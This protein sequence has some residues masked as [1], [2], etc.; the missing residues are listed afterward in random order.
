ML[1]LLLFAYVAIAFALG[2]WQA[3]V[4]RSNS[5]G[6]GGVFGF[7]LMA[8]LWPLLFFVF[9][10]HGMETTEYLARTRGKRKPLPVVG[11]VGRILKALTTF[12]S[13]RKAHG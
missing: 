7:F 6:D 3:R 11:D 1:Y 12:R 10:F 5:Y 9:M 8:W 2:I 13:E 4:A